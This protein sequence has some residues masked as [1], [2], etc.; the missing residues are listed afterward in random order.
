MKTRSLNIMSLS[1]LALL[2]LIAFRPSQNTF[3]KITVGEFELVDDKGKKR[4]SIKVQEGEVVFR[5]MDNSE[6]IRVKLGAGAEGSG[7]VL[8]DGNT[9]PV[10]HALA[11]KNAG[12]ITLT[13]KAGNKKVY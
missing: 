6:T 9:E 5:L 8:L 11:K 10:V 1:A 7:L 13:D 12:T 3:D 2:V 4:A